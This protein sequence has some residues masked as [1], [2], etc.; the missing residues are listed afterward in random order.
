MYGITVFYC[1]VLIRL[2]V[3][4]GFLATSLRQRH[5]NPEVQPRRVSDMYPRHKHLLIKRSQRCKK[6]E[7][8]LS[9]PEFNPSSIKFKIQLVALNHVPELRIMREPYLQPGKVSVL[10]AVLFHFSQ[11]GEVDCCDKQRI[12]Y[13]G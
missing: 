6:C 3:C 13:W 10:K 7:H 11:P 9:K 5:V 1:L 12:Y 2:I 8:N 4:F